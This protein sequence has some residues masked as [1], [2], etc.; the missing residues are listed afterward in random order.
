VE[1]WSSIAAA[2]V[3]CVALAISSASSLRAAKNRLKSAKAP[4]RST[5]SRSERLAAINAYLLV[6][7]IGLG[8]L[9]FAVMVALNL[10]DLAAL[11]SGSAV[12]DDVISAADSEL[13]AAPGRSFP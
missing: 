7:A 10:P 3:L 6:V 5:Q 12:Q 13:A 4:L 9:D 2:V 8:A 1:A 11:S